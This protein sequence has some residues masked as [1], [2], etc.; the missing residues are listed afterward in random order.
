MSISLIVFY[1]V[2]APGIVVPQRFPALSSFP[3]VH[4]VI[5]FRSHVFGARMGFVWASFKAHILGSSPFSTT[6]MIPPYPTHLPNDDFFSHMPEK[7]TLY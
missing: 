1:F 3:F 6:Q 4:P 2:L 5:R 7:V